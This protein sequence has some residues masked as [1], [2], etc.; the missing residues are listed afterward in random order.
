MNDDQRLEIWRLGREA[1]ERLIEEMGRLN[2][3]I[4][5]DG[6]DALEV[7]FAWWVGLMSIFPAARVNTEA[8]FARVVAAYMQF[9]TAQSLVS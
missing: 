1:S 4:S 6:S 5:D 2:I 3:V 8:E 9:Y 7:V